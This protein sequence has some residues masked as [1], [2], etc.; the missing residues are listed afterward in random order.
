M[1]ARD[2][3]PL[4]VDNPSEDADARSF[5]RFAGPSGW[6]NSSRLAGVGVIGTLTRRG[7]VD[8]AASSRAVSDVTGTPLSSSLFRARFLPLPSEGEGGVEGEV[9]TVSRF[10][11][12]EDGESWE[13]GT[14]EE[15]DMP[16]GSEGDFVLL[17]YSGARTRPNGS[18]CMDVDS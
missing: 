11:L 12:K 6:R 5:L 4:A 10:A 17:R 15:E 8:K 9:G 2:S 7:S 13:D 1:H 14:R 18:V 3:P 16:V